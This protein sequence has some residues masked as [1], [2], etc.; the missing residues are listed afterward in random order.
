MRFS[1]IRRRVKSNSICD[2]EGKPIS[3]SLKPS[4]TSNA[5]Y[6]SFSSTLMGTASAWLPSRRST[7]HHAAD[8]LSR[9]ECGGRG[10]PGLSQP[11]ARDR[12]GAGC[13]DAPTADRKLRDE[14]CGSGNG[15]VELDQTLFAPNELR[16]LGVGVGVGCKQH[17]GVARPLARNSP[18]N[19]LRIESAADAPFDPGLVDD[20]PRVD[21]DAVEIEDDRRH[22]Q[23]DVHTHYF[24]RPPE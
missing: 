12:I 11:G 6:S 19:Q 15:D 23:L 13:G 8:H 16:G 5:K 3:I 10:E 14:R 18:P 24:G 21:E 22:L 9:D 1:S 7:L 4:F 17:H 20:G 2:A